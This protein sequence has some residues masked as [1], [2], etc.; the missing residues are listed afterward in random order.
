MPDKKA[1]RLEIRR[2]IKRNRVAY[3]FISPFYIL[4]AIFGLFPIAMAIGLGFTNWRGD[5]SIDFI[6][7]KNYFDLFNSALFLKSLKNTLII[8][9]SGNAINL[10]GALALAYILNSKLV[11]R[12]YIFKVIYF[13]PMVTSAVASS[14]IYRALFNNNSGIINNLLENLGFDR[15]F[16]LGGT[17]DYL[18]IVVIV[19]FAWQWMGW[20]MVIYLA[21]MQGISPDITEAATIDGASH[22]SMFFKI[23]L[24]LLKPIILFTLIQS[25]I[26]TFIIF[27]E[28]FMLTGAMRMDGGANQQALTTVMFMLD[29]APYSRN[30]YGYAAAC[31]NVLCIIIITVSIIFTRTLGEKDET[32]QKLKPRK[33]WI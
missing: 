13:L 31:A 14:I 19:M 3:A 21:G 20:N 4:F 5:P 22:V 1:I 29:Q 28:P 7:L 24:P 12:P 8:G 10:S 11:R 25:T 27:T 32:K 30:N 9:V 2:E 26:G 15:I 18:K 23:V 6:G 16:W 33:V 17:G